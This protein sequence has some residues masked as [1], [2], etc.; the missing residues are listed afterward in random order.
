M[1][2][3]EEVGETS[4]STWPRGADAFTATEDRADATF[5]ERVC[6]TAT[7]TEGERGELP[8]PGERTPLVPVEIG[9]KLGIPYTLRYVLRE[10]LIEA[11][12]GA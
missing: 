11:T 6:T 1:P 7:A 3:T 12:H 10:A 2:R 4:R 5:A 8:N 9:R